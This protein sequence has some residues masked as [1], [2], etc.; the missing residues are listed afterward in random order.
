MAQEKR[1][2]K[3]RARDIFMR[4]GKN[5]VLDGVSI[6]ELHSW[7]S[8]DFH[9]DTQTQKEADLER[10]LHL[11]YPCQTPSFHWRCEIHCTSSAFWAIDRRVGLEKLA[12]LGLCCWSVQGQAS[13]ISESVVLEGTLVVLE[14]QKARDF[15]VVQC[16][17]CIKI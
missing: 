2:T 4:Q 1:C 16:P 3:V 17:C 7:E 12:C 5:G 8:W 13:Q 9:N 10:S 14:V 6:F 11:V 15:P